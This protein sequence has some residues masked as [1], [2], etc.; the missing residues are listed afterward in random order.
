MDPCAVYQH[1]MDYWA[2]T[3]QGDAGWKAETHRVL[4]VKKGKDGQPSKTV[5]RGW[6]CDLVPKALLVPVHF[7]AEQAALSHLAAEWDAAEAAR[8]EQ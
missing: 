1:A 4:E 5:D 3:M 8:A 6:A 7:A 2:V